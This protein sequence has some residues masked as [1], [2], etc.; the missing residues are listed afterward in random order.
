MKQPGRSAERE[1]AW[2]ERIGQRDEEAFRALFDAYYEQL[3]VFARLHLPTLEI[4]EEVVQDVLLSIWRR[5]SNWRLHGSL[6]PYLY[7]AVRRRCADY[8][9]RSHPTNLHQL[10]AAETYPSKESTEEALRERELR[11]ALQYALEAMPERRRLVFI[12]SRYQGLTY[13]E[14]AAVLGISVGTVE[15]QIV[16]ALKFLRERLAPL[17]SV[18][19]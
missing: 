2:V 16:R 3:V 9:R 15:V 13:S 5:G 18:F 17:L 11:H 14:I 7:G 4:A 6:R 12:L 19:L 8:T 10:E 1:A